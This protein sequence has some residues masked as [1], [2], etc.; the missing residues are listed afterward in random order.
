MAFGS[1]LATEERPVK[2]GVRTV[3]PQ[4]VINIEHVEGTGDLVQMNFEPG[5][6]DDRALVADVAR[7]NELTG[8]KTTDL[9]RIQPSKEGEPVRARF[10][11]ANILDPA[12][13]DI[14]L[15][16]VIRSFM[17]GA[18]GKRVDS[19][20]IRILGQQ[21]SPY[22]TLASYSSHAVALKAFF[23][24]ATPCIEYRILVL[25]KTPAE[26][27]IPPRHIPDPVALTRDEPKPPRGPLLL[28]LVLL[29]GASA[30]ALVYFS[31]LGKRD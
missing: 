20:S 5:M 9:E 30:G 18:D 4:V 26:V 23:D 29:A 1:V 12:E 15:Q 13:G 19:F 28:T 8:S 16:P 22:T 6:Y 11:A 10:T 27:D 21:P 3:E 7:L 2:D 24:A 25:A 31:L 14:R 17:A